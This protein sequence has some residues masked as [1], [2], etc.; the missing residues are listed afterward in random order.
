M[1]FIVF[2][3]ISALMLLALHTCQDQF[4]MF[5][6]ITRFKRLDTVMTNTHSYIQYALVDHKVGFIYKKTKQRK[7]FKKNSTNWKFIDTGIPC[8]ERSISRLDEAD[9]AQFKFNSQ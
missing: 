8:P 1:I 2:L 4:E 7:V 5:S 9:E 3:I 6:T